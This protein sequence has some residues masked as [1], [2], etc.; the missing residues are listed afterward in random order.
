MENV[1]RS[2]TWLWLA[3]RVSAMVLAVCVIVHIA[4]MIYAVQQGLSTAAISAR[5]SGNLMWL[6]FYT[7]FVAAVSIHAPI[8]VRTV[9]LEATELPQKRVGL[10]AMLFGLFILVLGFR[11]I[12]GLY[13]M[14]L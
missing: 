14:S 10:L 12:F 4:T 8:G 9:L 13:G 6:G 7:T 5:I 11:A 1:A 2:E 3:Q